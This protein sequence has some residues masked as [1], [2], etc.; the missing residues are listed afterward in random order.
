[1]LDLISGRFDDDQFWFDSRLLQKRLGEMSL[2][3]CQF[4][5]ARANSEYPIQFFCFKR[6][7]K[8]SIW[9]SPEF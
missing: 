4:A 2:P 3:K 7:L 6:I 5:T 1:V 9:S 8:T